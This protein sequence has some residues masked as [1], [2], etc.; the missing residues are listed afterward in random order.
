MLTHAA[1]QSNSTLGG[2]ARLTKPFRLTHARDS[3]LVH[4]VLDE[5]VGSDDQREH[6]GADGQRAA[7]EHVERGLLIHVVAELGE[8]EHRVLR[9][10][11]HGREDAGGARGE[12]DGRGG[13]LLGSL[14]DGLGAAIGVRD[15]REMSGDGSD[16]VRVAR[17][18]KSGPDR[19]F[20]PSDFN[21][22][23]PGDN[24]GAA[25]G[26]A[27]NLGRRDDLVEGENLAHCLVCLYIASRVALRLCGATA[28][29]DE[30]AIG[31]QSSKRGQSTRPVG[32]KSNSLCVAR[33]GLAPCTGDGG[34]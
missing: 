5:E 14:G 29:S 15:G 21:A 3:L 32:A 6:R 8:L 9:L 19:A 33:R 12:R 13:L 10:G 30:A 23:V 22:L 2:M 25:D 16:G 11:G 20:V 34:V 28:G 31:D 17:T 27:G 1:F 24:L 26:A 4:D 18:G 7:D